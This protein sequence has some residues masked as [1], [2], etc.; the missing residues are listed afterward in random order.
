MVL[1]VDTG[2]LDITLRQGESFS[3]TLTFKEVDANGVRSAMDLSALSGG[4]S[5]ATAYFRSDYGS[6]SETVANLITTSTPTIAY[7]T[8]GTDGQ[9]TLSLTATQVGEIYAALDDTDPPEA[10]EE[11]IDAVPTGRWSLHFDFG[12]GAREYLRG[13][14]TVDRQVK[15]S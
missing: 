6:N 14:V 8:D 12:S 10:G 5:G 3:L 15:D 1:S 13:A 2:K 7:V 11:N 4:I 9:V